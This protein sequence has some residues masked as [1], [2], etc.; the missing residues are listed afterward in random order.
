VGFIEARNFKSEVEK[1]ES[2]CGVDVDSIL[3]EWDVGKGSES[4]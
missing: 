3:Q 4:K 1:L 2:D